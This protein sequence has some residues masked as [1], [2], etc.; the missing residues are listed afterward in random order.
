[1]QELCRRWETGELQKL[2]AIHDLSRAKSGGAH[3]ILSA[4]AGE[5]SSVTAP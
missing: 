1:M 3:A 4:I 5:K 2:R